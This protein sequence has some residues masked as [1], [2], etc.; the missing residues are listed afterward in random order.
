MWTGLT[1]NISPRRNTI[2]TQETISAWFWM[3]NSWLITG[4]FLFVFFRIPMSTRLGP[5]LTS[6]CADEVGFFQ[7]FF[8][9]P[10]VRRHSKLPPAPYEQ[11]A[12]QKLNGVSLFCLWEGSSSRLTNDTTG[13]AA[14]ALYRHLKVWS[15]NTITAP[16]PFSSYMRCF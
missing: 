9:N 7:M 11:R 16:F 3:T 12:R 14:G 15:N 4:G 5:T 8:E 6:R 1:S 10:S 2:A 13:E